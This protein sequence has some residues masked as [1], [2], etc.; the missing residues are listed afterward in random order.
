VEAVFL[1]TVKKAQK[2]IEGK[3][4]SEPGSKKGKRNA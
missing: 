3:N 2:K 1:E 4:A